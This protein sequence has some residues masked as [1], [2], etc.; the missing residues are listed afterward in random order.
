MKWEYTAI[1]KQVVQ[2]FVATKLLSAVYGSNTRHDRFHAKIE[3][4]K[5]YR[6]LMVNE[7]RQLPGLA[8][9]KKYVERLM[10]LLDREPNGFLG[11]LAK[12]DSPDLRKNIFEKI[13]EAESLDS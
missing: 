1:E 5:H 6:L 13:A 7:K 4:I 8:Y 10:D 9:S 3:A 12:W 2:M 11:Y